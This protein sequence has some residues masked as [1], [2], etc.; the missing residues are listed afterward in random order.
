M[1][2]IQPTNFDEATRIHPEG[3]GRYTATIDRL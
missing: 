1:T 3:D 2:A